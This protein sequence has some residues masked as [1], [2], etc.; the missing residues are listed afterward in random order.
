MCIRDRSTWDAVYCH[1]RRT[2]GSIVES[3]TTH[4]KTSVNSEQ[5]KRSNVV[6]EMAKSKNHTNH[7]QTRKAHKNGIHKARKYRQ[8]PTK[9]MCPKFLRNQRA[10]KKG[11]VALKK[12]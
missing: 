11:V 9:G 6:V 2:Y 4:N 8:M 3:Q 1:S 10:A 12:K 7:N 5:S